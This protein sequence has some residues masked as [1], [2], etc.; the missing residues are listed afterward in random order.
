MTEAIMLVLWF[1]TVMFFGIREYTKRNQRESHELWISELQ[2]CL[3]RIESEFH[4]HCQEIAEASQAQRDYDLYKTQINELKKEY[5]NELYNKVAEKK[6]KGFAK[7]LPGY[8]V[9]EYEANISKITDIYLDLGN[10]YLR[11]R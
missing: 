4:R 7:T 6:W 3:R 9:K 2:D 10:L 1:G 8:I 5:L 11:R